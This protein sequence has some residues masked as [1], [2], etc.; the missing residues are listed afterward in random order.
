VAE[1]G[2][3]IPSAILQSVNKCACSLL[4]NPEFLPPDEYDRRS[5]VA[6][7]ISLGVVPVRN[8]FSTRSGC[9]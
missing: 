1:T 3:K 2:D 8:A 7:G 9:F 6:K 4:V 5:A